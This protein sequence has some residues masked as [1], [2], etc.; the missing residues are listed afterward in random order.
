MINVFPVSMT[1]VNWPTLREYGPE[2]IRKLDEHRIKL[3]SLSS[4]VQAVGYM[5]FAQ[6]QNPIN[7]L[8]QESGELLG[9]VSMGFLIS[10]PTDVQMGFILASKVAC[11]NGKGNTRIATATIKQWQEAVV[12]CCKSGTSSYVRIIG[13]RIFEYIEQAGFREIWSGYKKVAMQD[14]AFELWKL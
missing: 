8:R 1:L 2:V 11:S 6:D 14:G 3:E 4:Y 7:L 10:A 5:E 13:N 9:H 12:N